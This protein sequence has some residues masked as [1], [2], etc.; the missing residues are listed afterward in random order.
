MPFQSLSLSGSALSAT[1]AAR[2][3]AASTFRSIATPISHSM[4]QHANTR[5]SQAGR[6][7][8]A[9]ELNDPR[10]MTAVTKVID[11]VLVSGKRRANDSS[12]SAEKTSQPSKQTRMQAALEA[13]GMAESFLRHSGSKTR[14]LS[15]AECSAKYA[16]ESREG[17]SRDA[18]THYVKGGWGKADIAAH[19]QSILR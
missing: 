4:S 15:E 1:N 3:H 18:R 14:Y 6:D 5:I 19:L 10:R 13:A 12:A 2:T 11:D 7:A 8:A 16:V 17:A 9:R